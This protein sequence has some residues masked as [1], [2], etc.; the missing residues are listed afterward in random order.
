MFRDQR[1][2]RF[3]RIQLFNAQLAGMPFHHFQ[4]FTELSCEKVKVEIWSDS[5]KHSIPLTLNPEP[6][7]LLVPSGHQ[8]L[9]S[10]LVDLVDDVGHCVINA[11]LL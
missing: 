4:E 2:A 1:A 9:L 11:V 8:K 6:L 7:N 10:A 3:Q 5:Q